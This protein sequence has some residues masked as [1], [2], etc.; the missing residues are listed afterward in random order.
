MKSIHRHVEIIDIFL[1]IVQFL[2]AA[3]EVHNQPDAVS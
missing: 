3:G 1:P 2:D